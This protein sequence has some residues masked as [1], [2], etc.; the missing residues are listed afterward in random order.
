MCLILGTMTKGAPPHKTIVTPASGR[1][2]G[3]AATQTSRQVVSWLQQGWT[4]IYDPLE[5]RVR[6]K[7]YLIKSNVTKTIHIFNT[8]LTIQ[9][10][11]ILA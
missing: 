8:Y 6:L 7:L 3:H 1:S 5:Y 10:H 11:R 9:E 4:P 2:C